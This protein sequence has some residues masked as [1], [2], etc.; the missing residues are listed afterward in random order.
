[1]IDI[2]RM[3]YVF[4]FLSLTCTYALAPAYADV[5]SHNGTVLDEETS[6]IPVAFETEGGINGNYSVYFF[7]NIHCNHCQAAIRYLEEYGSSRTDF[8]VKSYDLYENKEVRELFE[9]FKQEYNLPHISYPAMFIGDVVL[10]GS[11]SIERHFAPLYEENQK[12]KEQQTDF[13]RG[14]FVFFDKEAAKQLK[15]SP[16]L[17]IGAGLLDGINPCAFAV[18]VLLLVYLMAMDTKR[19]MLLAGTAYIVAVFI[20]YFLSGLGLFA[21][22]QATGLVETFLILSGIIALAAGILTLKDGIIPGKGPSLAI[23]ESRK[24]TINRFITKSTIPAAF[25][26][27]ILVGMFELPCTGG[28]YLVIINMIALETNLVGGI[29]WL[30]LYNVMFIMPLII[31]LL[32]VCYGMP[33]EK[34]NEW[35]LSQR[36]ILKVIIGLIMIALGMWILFFSGSL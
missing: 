21:V 25:I 32:A 28:I 19:R 29:T 15:L 13:T 16:L 1:M 35:R 8:S 10:E 27:G 2:K 31:I 26:L 3:L 18:L 30:L 5:F 24:G 9:G 22:I 33:P 14:F 11:P 12:R 36:R 7:Y 17:V 20:F 4:L 6:L 23:P 34:V